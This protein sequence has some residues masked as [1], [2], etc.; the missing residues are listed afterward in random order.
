MR[1]SELQYYIDK[2]VDIRK[3]V[4]RLT[5]DI[6]D[7]EEAAI[8]QPK[9]RLEAGRL[10]AQMALNTSTLKRRLARIV[11]KKSLKIRHREDRITESAIKNS[12][13]LDDE[14]QKAQKHFDKSEAYSELV[15]QLVECYKERTMMI[16]VLTRLRA[17]EINS[18]IA[19]VRGEEEMKSMRH[20]ARNVKD[21]FAEFE[22]SE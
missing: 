8:K 10:K 22:E 6:D 1:H 13:S 21:Q 19:S 5:F 12:L 7:L 16:S 4:D 20:K 11:G 3:L 15:S 9:L 14:V 2:P 17:S 18:Q